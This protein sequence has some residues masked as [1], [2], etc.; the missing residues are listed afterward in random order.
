MCGAVDA[1]QHKDYANND[2]YDV[3]FDQTLPLNIFQ[4][5]LQ[6]VFLICIPGI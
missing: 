3:E 5:L 6:P 4:C 1:S 2:V